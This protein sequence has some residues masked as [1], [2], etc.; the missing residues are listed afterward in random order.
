[1][2][3]DGLKG[4]ALPNTSK[5]SNEMATKKVVKK[6]YNPRVHSGWDKDMITLGRRRK[7]IIAHKTYLAAARSL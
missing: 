7:A 6:W 2:G 1:M 4:S 3:S 5:R